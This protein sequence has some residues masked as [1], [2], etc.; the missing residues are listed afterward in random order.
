MGQHSVVFHFVW[1]IDCNWQTDYAGG[2]GFSL[3]IQVETCNLAMTPVWRE[4]VCV[5][6]SVYFT[7]SSIF[8]Y[9]LARNARCA[10]VCIN[11]QKTGS[12]THTFVEDSISFESDDRWRHSFF[13]NTNRKNASAH[14]KWSSWRR[15][16][17]T[18]TRK[19]HNTMRRSALFQKNGAKKIFFEWC[20]VVR[21]RATH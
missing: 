5:C 3:A 20:K 14:T 17:L 6:V 7:L 4:R 2:D 15:V 16:E 1:S 11:G 9:E 10:C 19:D 12:H 13:L 8:P 21:V 18:T